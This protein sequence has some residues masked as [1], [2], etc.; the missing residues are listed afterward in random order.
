VTFLGGEG[1]DTLIGFKT[2]STWNVTGANAGTVNSQVTFD[3]VENLVGAADNQDTFIVEEG[4]RLSGI[5]DGGARGFDTLVLPGV[6]SGSYT[7]GHVFGDGVVRADQRLISFTGLEPVVIDG[8][9][10]TGSQSG[11]NTSGLATTFTFTTPGGADVITV[12][13]P[14]VGQ[15]KISGTSGG[16]AFESITFRNVGTVIIDTGTNDSAGSQD[17]TINF[18]GN[19]AALG[20]TQVTVRTGAGNDKI[21]LSQIGATGSVQV[22]IY[23]QAGTDEIVGP[24]KDNAWRITGANSGTLNTNITFTDCENLT[25]VSAGD[26]HFT[27][28]PGWQ[29]ERIDHRPAR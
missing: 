18:V 1:E 14:A 13:S 25:S 5:L 16:V 10:V 24:L 7:P 27:L 12:D 26:D 23:G 28:L 8:T 15:N 2:D 22:F 3:G 20:L 11:L 19:L 9:T 4:G 21:D 17:D 29:P 6:T